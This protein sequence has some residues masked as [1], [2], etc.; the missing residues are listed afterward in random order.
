MPS[1]VVV[2][3]ATGYTG[4]LVVADLVR[5]GQRPVVAGRDP[6]RVRALAEEHGGLPTATADVARPGTL[7]GLV[8]RGDVLVSTVGPFVR[9]GR[10][11]LEAAID[12]GAHYLDCCGEPAFYRHVFTEAAPKARAAGSA[13]L[14]GF[15]F[16]FVPGH[17]AG[18]LAVRE[19]GG[20]AR[21]LDIGYFFTDGTRFSTGTRATT[22][23]ALD[24]RGHAFR[25]GRLVLEP[26][27]RHSRS[28]PDATGHRRAIFYGGTEPLALPRT[29]PRLTHIATYVGGTGIPAQGARLASYVL[30][31]LMRVPG[32]AHT[33]RRPAERALRRTGDG[34]DATARATGGSRVIAV[35]SA[36]TGRPLATV[37]LDGV[38]AYTFTAR[39]LAHTAPR[40]AAGTVTDV[41]ALGPLDLFGLPELREAVGKAGL[42]RCPE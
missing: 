22:R 3:G 29:E 25:D 6:E 7:R 28:F 31:P 19:T 11:A 17:L 27:G 15:G 12:A 8:E 21:R 5:C 10:P 16:D 4:R 14:T 9:Y 42:H 23:L 37:S 36:D 33:L 26:L 35:A 2:F 40:L 41:G 1:R 39:F 30:P 38:D 13:L 34:P 18:A 32:I 24:Q 20:A